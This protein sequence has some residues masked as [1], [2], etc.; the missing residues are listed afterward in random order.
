MQVCNQQCKAGALDH[1]ELCAHGFLGLASGHI[2]LQVRAFPVPFSP[3]APPPP[4]SPPGPLLLIGAKGKL[5]AAGQLINPFQQHDVF[6]D[7][8]TLISFTVGLMFA[9]K[10]PADH[11]QQRS[12]FFVTPYCA[13][14]AMI[15]DCCSPVCM[16]SVPTTLSARCQTCGKML[17]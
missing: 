7:L 2:C 4:T 15:H 10:S 5:E 9:T 1:P 11:V 8:L 6:S 16:L 14:P 17:R 12:L 3:H 13:D